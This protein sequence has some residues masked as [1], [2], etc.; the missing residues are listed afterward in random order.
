[1]SG[2]TPS[3]VFDT[4]WTFVSRRHEAYE[5]RLVQPDG[6][7]TDDPI[8]AAHRF[9]NVFR[10]ADR[11]SQRLIADVQGPDRSSALDEVFY[12][13]M[14][15]KTFNSERTWDAV[16]S[17]LG[18]ISWQRT[19]PSE[20]A[21]VL[22]GL[23]SRGVAIYSAAY[24]MPS[25]PHG[26]ER[27]HRNHLAAI[28]L[29]MRDG[30]PASV[31]SASSLEEVYDLLLARPGL[32]RFL[33]F[34][35]AVDLSYSDVVPFDDSGFVVAGPGAIDGL[36]KCFLDADGM[37]PEELI[38]WTGSRMEIELDR[39]GLPFGG[40]FGRR[41]SPVDWQ[42]CFCEI[43]KYARVAHPDVVGS[44]GRTRI[45]QRYDA[46]GARP[47]PRPVLPAKWGVRIP[48]SAGTTATPDLF[49]GLAPRR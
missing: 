3:P 21:A 11:V 1:M 45:K 24:I 5:R 20:I 29:M 37:S 4:Y 49:G 47:L 16:E 34:Q 40:L 33:A 42:N 28:D 35:Y 15:F 44:S 18:P 46:R 30:L 8:L 22:D 36:S 13:T 41:P 10:A 6:P 27:K 26:H 7:W 31:A 17:R 2:P 12:R 48:P 32:G 39:L 14:L 38:G 23:H 43:S 25:P 9:T 19:P